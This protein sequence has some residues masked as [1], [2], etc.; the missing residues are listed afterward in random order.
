MEKNRVTLKGNLGSKPE[1]FEKENGTSYTRLNIAINNYKKNDD[2]S[3]ETTSTDWF[4]V[5]CFGKPSNLAARASIL[6]VGDLIRIQGRL[7]TSKY[8]KNSI[9]INAINII[10]TEVEKIEPLRDHKISKAVNHLSKA[11]DIGMETEAN[12]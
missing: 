7:T 11:I 9:E 8:E 12:V 10:A 3:Y 1:Y 4:N 6:E 5:T 2:G